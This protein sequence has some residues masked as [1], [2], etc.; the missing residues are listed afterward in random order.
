MHRYAISFS[1]ST[2]MEPAWQEAIVQAAIKRIEFSCSA[3]VNASNIEEKVNTL[4]K[5]QEDGKVIVASIHIPFG[6]GWY[7][8]D[9]DE[10]A[11]AETVKN[12]IEFMEACKPLNCPE[13]TLHGSLEPTPPELR[14]DYMKACKK[15]LA[16][17]VPTARKL[18]AHVNVEILPR[19][20]LGRTAE[21]MAEII[22]GLPEEI[23][24]C[25]D[26]NHLNGCPET[27]PQAINLLADRINT[28]HISDYDGIDECHWYPF[29]G[30]ID[31][32]AVMEAINNL[33]NDVLL[34][35]ECAGFVKV[36]QKRP[37]DPKIIFDSM[38]HNAFL[39]ENA[40]EIMRRTKE[41]VLN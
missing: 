17:L 3:A 7:F 1:D 29:M 27:L 39:L 9:P 32:A 15:T 10:N 6:G 19:T 38:L 31:W 13:F 21:E 8:A 12:T 22:D 5:L 23:G 25:F 41:L 30:C 11:R 18:K 26:V 34:I 40:A 28:F 14:N 35:F 37:M 33:R 36:P 16:E 24:V 4:A 20:C 2:V